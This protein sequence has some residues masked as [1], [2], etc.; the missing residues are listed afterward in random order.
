MHTYR[1]N[2]DPSQGARKRQQVILARRQQRIGALVEM[3]VELVDHIRRQHTGGEGGGREGQ[4]GELH[5]VV[6]L[7]L[8]RRARGL[9]VMMA[10]L[11]SAG[12]S[13]MDENGG[14]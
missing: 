5:S 11:M 2:F 13:G 3:P 12:L 4:A 14:E 10:C 1:I 7:V 6:L 8:L 9:A